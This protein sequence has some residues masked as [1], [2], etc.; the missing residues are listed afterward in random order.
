MDGEAPGTALKMD[1]VRVVLWVGGA[2]CTHHQD[3]CAP[4]NMAEERG[5][6]MGTS[7]RGVTS[8]WHSLALGMERSLSAVRLWVL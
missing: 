2:M 7:Q 1:Q 3:I 6:V 5:W 4:H 8:A